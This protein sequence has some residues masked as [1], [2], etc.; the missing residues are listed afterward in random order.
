MNEVVSE[1]T[2]TKGKEYCKKMNEVTA[3]PQKRKVKSIVEK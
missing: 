3:K 2:K 1:A